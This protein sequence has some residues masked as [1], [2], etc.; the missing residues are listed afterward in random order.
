MYSAEDIRN[1]AFTR[2][3]GGYKTAEVDDFIDAVADTVE[4]LL[5]QNAEQTKKLEVLAE[6]LMEYR[7]D[8]DNIHT[9]LLSAQRAGDA[10]LR[11]AQHKAELI[12]EDAALKADKAKEIAE[13]EIQAERE[14]LRRVTEE[15]AAFKKALLEM[16]RQHLTV[17]DALPAEEAPAEEEAAVV[18]T[19]EEPAPAPTEPAEPMDEVF[20]SS[21]AE[22]AAAADATPETEEADAADEE[23]EA[24]AAEGEPS[25]FPP[26]EPETPPTSRF[27]D[28]QFGPEYEIDGETRRR[29][30]KRKQS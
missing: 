21:E 4:A 16:Y 30:G 24:D 17:I 23:E 8:E 19:A 29:F 12:L 1:V 26:E 15:V 2:M 5:R 14:E 20:S 10:L 11:E 28:L 27:S 6:R 3:M 13:R 22:A 9:A 18:E 7:K 25:L